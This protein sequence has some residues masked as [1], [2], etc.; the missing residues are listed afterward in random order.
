MFL[1]KIDKEDKVSTKSCRTLSKIAEKATT[2]RL[3]C[4]KIILLQVYL[5]HKVSPFLRSSHLLMRVLRHLLVMKT[6]RNRL[7]RRSLLTYNKSVIR[8]TEWSLIKILL[9]TQTIHLL[10]SVKTITNRNDNYSWKENWK[11][12]LLEIKIKF[13]IKRER[14]LICIRMCFPKTKVSQF[15]IQI[16]N[17]HL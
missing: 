15:R 1:K 12:I 8:P 17:K 14:S 3:L 13:P 4:P 9:L 7:L 16:K 10:G 2:R 6:N 11:P 5:N